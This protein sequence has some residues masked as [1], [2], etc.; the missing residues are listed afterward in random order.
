MYDPYKYSLGK[1]NGRSAD[2]SVANFLGF[3]ADHVSGN[4]IYGRV[5]NVVGVVDPDAGP[6]PDLLF[7]KAIR[8]VE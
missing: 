8:L 2:Y 3:F 1:Q 4:S 5:T 7:P 6:V